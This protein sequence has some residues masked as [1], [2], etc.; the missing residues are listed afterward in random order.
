MTN[1]KRKTRNTSLLDYYASATAKVLADSMNYQM[2]EKSFLISKPKKYWYEP[3]FTVNIPYP[4]L[5]Q[6]YDGER[7]GLFI[8]WKEINIGKRKVVNKT[9]KEEMKLWKK[10]KTMTFTRYGKLDDTTEG[11]GKS[12]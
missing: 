7:T 10:P 1:S 5:D 3:R 11:K 9:Y 2:F 8:G 12:P 4:Y 6:E